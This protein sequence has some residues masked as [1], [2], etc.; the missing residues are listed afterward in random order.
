MYYSKINGVYKRY[1]LGPDKGKFITGQF[2]LP[3]YERL[4]DV[5]WFWTEKLDGTNAGVI[6][7]DIGPKFIGRTNKTVMSGPMV[8]ALEAFADNHDSLNSK[9]VT[10]YGELVGPKIQGN[11]YEL[12]EV[13]FVPFDV[14]TPMGK[15]WPKRYVYET[16]GDEAVRQVGPATLRRAID[17]FSNENTLIPATEEGWVGSAELCDLYGKRIAT[18]LKWVD[19]L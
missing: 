14:R 1:D 7:G 12:D 3:E 16:F 17:F 2:S 4:L 9:D 15:Y 10:V 19:F 8:E 13:R 5:D 11:L 18:K 6:F